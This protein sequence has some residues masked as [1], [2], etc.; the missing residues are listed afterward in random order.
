M[1]DDFLDSLNFNVAVDDSDD[2]DDATLIDINARSNG[3]RHVQCRLAPTRTIRSLK[4]KIFKAHPDC[5]PDRTR[6]LFNGKALDSDDA[7]LASLH[8]SK[9]ADLFFVLRP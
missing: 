4:R 1:D 3:G 9:T 5:P 6:L 8:V 7:T 2:D